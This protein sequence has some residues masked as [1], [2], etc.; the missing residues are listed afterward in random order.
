MKKLVLYLISKDSKSDFLK[1]TLEGKILESKVVTNK[2]IPKWYCKGERCSIIGSQ[3]IKETEEKWEIHKK[4]GETFELEITRRK[5]TY[6]ERTSEA[7]FEDYFNKKIVYEDMTI[8]DLEE[9]GE[10]EEGYNSRNAPEIGG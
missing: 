1:L 7:I 9:Y 3:D 8:K 5:T 2:K 6:K 10:V 4:N